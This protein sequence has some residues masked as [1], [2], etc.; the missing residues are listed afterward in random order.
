MDDF[1]KITV[2]E[3]TYVENNIYDHICFLKRS[4]KSVRKFAFDALHS[5]T[6]QQMYIK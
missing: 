1:L 5:Y 2:L 6:H 4:L 3:E